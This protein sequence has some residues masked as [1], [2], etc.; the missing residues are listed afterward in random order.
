MH[1]RL[2]LFYFFT[3]MNVKTLLFEHPR[4]AS[5][6]H[7]NDVANAPLSACL[8]SGYVAAVLKQNGFAADIYDAYLSDESFAESFQKLSEMDFDVLGIHTVYFWEHTPELFSMLQKLKELKP[9]VPLLLY[10]VF[11]SFAY[12][13]IF[14]LYPFIDAVILGEPEETFYDIVRTYQQ[15]GCLCCANIAGTAYND[16]GSVY[17]NKSRVLID[18]LDR[19]PFP[20]RS[21][22]SLSMLGGTVL[23]SR[24][25]YGNCSFCC[26]NPFYGTASSWRGRSP[27]NIVK[28]IKLLL[29]RLNRKY[30]YFLDA[31]FFGKGRQ[32]HA[33]VLEI[34]DRIKDLAI[35]FGFECRSNDIDAETIS[36]LAHAGL[37]DVFIGIESASRIS[38]GRMNK[39]IT[40]PRS[41][42]AVKILQN[43]GIALTPGFIMFEP[44]ASLSDI[45]TNFEFLK[46]HNL[47]DKLHTTAN[48]L[49][50]REIIL[51]AM[52]NFKRLDAQGRLAEKDMLE[53]E[54]GYC[55]TE[56]S[57][58]FLADLMST[59]C[60]HV[61]KL[62]ESSQSPICWQKQENDTSAKVNTF[63]VAL[64]DDVLRKLECKAIS[65]NSHEQSRLQE[66]SLQYIE[67]LIFEKQVCQS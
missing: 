51:R 6:A 64:F 41:E 47:L 27:E 20:V 22:L 43:Y 11:P 17:I 1:E 50:H 59:V 26:I 24:G 23:G 58:N 40:S 29:P 36:C 2:Q 44:D 48:V 21:N 10:G 37:K 54:G 18:P 25:C 15:K 28:E 13:H 19:L 61:L 9:A 62:T 60:R 31:N 45:R 66:E 56:S 34:A 65:L 67:G 46:A 12:K 5:D 35:A 33:R 63:L 57:V 16:N 8:M 4:I 39:G 7:Y 55:F 42:H 53:Y 49:Y 38:L 14:S 3:L 30:V 32:G 52:Q